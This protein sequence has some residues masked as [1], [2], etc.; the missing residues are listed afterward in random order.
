MLV[1]PYLFFEGRC[2]EALEFYKKAL[3]AQVTMLMRN[4]DNPEPEG[5]KMQMP[6][7]TENK[8]MHCEFKI[9]ETTLM[10]SDGFCRGASAFQGFSLAISV[11][12]AAQAR[13]AF[14]ALSEGGK[15]DM[16]L[17]KTFFSES[18]GMLT[19]KFGIGWMLQT[20]PK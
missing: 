1:Q 12:D 11:A 4:K 17:A 9:G 19:D 20:T 2:E 13:K 10:C 5:N 3:G 6:P 16:P 7:G 15:V 14:D 8:V 18:F